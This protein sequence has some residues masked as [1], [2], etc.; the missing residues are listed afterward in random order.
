MRWQ[1]AAVAA[2]EGII[3]TWIIIL[4]LTIIVVLVR[5]ITEINVFCCNQRFPVVQGRTVEISL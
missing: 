4:V 2:V 3:F 5:I 1:V